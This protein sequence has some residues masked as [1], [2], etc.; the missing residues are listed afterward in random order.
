MTCKLNNFVLWC[1]GWYTPIDKEM[2]IW[3]QLRLMLIL[4]GYGFIKSRKDILAICLSYFSEYCDKMREINHFVLCSRIDYF[5][6]EVG[7]NKHFYSLD[8]E[9]AIIYTLKHAFY[10]DNKLDLIGPVIYNKSFQFVPS[11]Y[12]PGMT[13]KEMNK[14]AKKHFKQIN[15]NTYNFKSYFNK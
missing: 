11:C 12:T 15:D 3:D 8:D 7:K 2:N 14:I 6:S 1:K 10:C 9:T 4:D 5:L 13:Y